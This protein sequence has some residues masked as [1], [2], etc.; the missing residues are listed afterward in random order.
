MS[1]S[2]QEEVS[3]GTL[4]SITLS[5]KFIERTDIHLYINDVEMDRVGGSTPYLWDW[6]SDTL[7]SITPAVALASV[8]LVRRQSALA[9]MYHNFDAGAVFKAESVDEN[10]T[11]VLN[12]AQE[13]LEG[14]GPTDYYAD[15]D[16]HGNVIGNAGLAVLPG[17]LLSLG[18]YQASG[19]FNTA[20]Y[21]GDYR[22]DI[23]FQSYDQVFKYLGNFYAPAPNTVLPYTTTGVGAV[24]VATFRNV[25]DALLRSGLKNAT[26]FLVDASV[27]GMIRSET[28]AV[29]RTSKSKGLAVITVEDFGAVAGGIVDCAPAIRRALD[30]VPAGGGIVEFESSGPYLVG[31]VVFI[32]QRSGVFNSPG[33]T[34]RGKHTKLIGSGANTCF[35]SGT[36]ALST[37][38]ATNFGLPPQSVESIHY[39][40]K[41]EGFVFSGFGNC[42][43]LFNFIQGCALTDLYAT[44]I[45][46]FIYAKSCFYL[47][48]TRIQGRPLQSARAATTPIL[49]FDVDCNTI[50]FNDV[51]VSGVDAGGLKRGIG[52][53]FSGGV[54]AILL[55]NASAEGCVTGI[56]LES[57]IYNMNVDSVYFEYN[58]NHIVGTGANLLHLVVDNCW[59]DSGAVAINANGWAGGK[60][61]NGNYFSPA[62]G[63][64]NLGAGCSCEVY[65]PE[66]MLSSLNHASWVNNPAGWTINASCKVVRNDAIFNIGVGLNSQWFRNNSDSSGNQVVPLSFTGECFNVGG[67]VPY[68]TVTGVGTG[69]LTVNTKIKW[70]PNLSSVRF[71][72]VVIHSSTAVIAGVV[73]A[74]NT[75]FRDDASGFTVTSTDSGGFVRL[76]FGGFGVITSF[77]GKVRII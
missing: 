72:M 28:G 26:P 49:W 76:S 34:I 41:I 57:F 67:I 69:T 12:L 44:A 11:Q 48:L 68:C 17:D 29:E 21:L 40:S 37:G 61:G 70:N 23:V 63:T 39:N 60:L 1:F 66:Q 9:G 58:D 7:L 75:I 51:H 74:N 32:P 71:D 27:V 2:I 59:F 19:A 13:Y 36:G 65:L 15:V 64:V 77:S 16:L 18:Q 43:R 52:I 46:T 22:A 73:S 33:I 10:F 30:A 47:G 14:K 6:V 38:G 53:K 3:N 56:K 42:I 24:E 50:T 5:I 20:Y 55:T 25:G 4:N 8:V 54:A 35:E 62:A 31:S 45:D